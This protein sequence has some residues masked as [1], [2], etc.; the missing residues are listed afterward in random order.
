MK[1]DDKTIRCVVVTPEAPIVDTQA[2]EVIIPAHDGMIG[3]LPGHA[4]LLCNLGMGIVCY[5]K[6]IQMS[7]IKKDLTKVEESQKKFVE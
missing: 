7:F 4:P 5:K 3:L 1:K 2:T 6:D